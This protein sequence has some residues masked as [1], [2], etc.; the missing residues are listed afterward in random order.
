MKPT[1]VKAGASCPPSGKTAKVKMYGGGMAM[2]KKSMGYGHG[3]MA[4]KKK[5]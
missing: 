2:K 5:K 3:G 4:M 1:K